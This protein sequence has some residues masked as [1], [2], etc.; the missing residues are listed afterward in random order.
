M[1]RHKPTRPLVSPPAGRVGIHTHLVVYKMA[2]TRPHPSVVLS[3]LAEGKPPT[4]LLAYAPQLRVPQLS[5]RTGTA[6]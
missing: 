3:T 1:R 6:I 2:H 4:S 5:L